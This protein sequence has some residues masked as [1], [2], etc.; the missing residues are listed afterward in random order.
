MTESAI[1][2]TRIRQQRLSQ[3]LR[4]SAL[5]QKAGISPSYLNL[6]EHNRRRIGGKIL[7]RL[8]EALNVEPQI[9]SQ[10]G[11]AAL[12]AGLREAAAEPGDTLPEAERLE[13][14]VGRF[15]GWAQLLVQAHRRGE[16]RER[17]VQALIN[18]LAH[19][20]HLAESIHEVLSVVAAI[21]STASILVETPALEPEWQARFHRNINEDAHRLTE[22]AE[23]LVQYLEAAP[24]SDTDIRSPQDELDQF[25]AAHAYHFAALEQGGDIDALVQRSDVLTLPSAVHLA[26][27]ALA[28]YVEDAAR[29]PIAGMARAL[30]HLGCDPVQLAQHLGVGL[31]VMLRRLAALP[32]EM[33]GPLG[34]VVVDGSGTMVMRKP[35]EGFA[36]T[37]LAG[38][39]PLWPVFRVLAQPGAALRQVIVQPG[40]DARAVTALACAEPVGPPIVNM[41]PLLR[42]V[43]LLSPDLGGD[44]APGPVGSSCRICARQGCVARRE[45][46]VLQDNG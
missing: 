42:G 4:Q 11:E 23:A 19:D 37:R 7:L 35:L 31:P 1:T 34:L 30:R 33:V 14:F 29:L 15:P 38:S 20:P 43:M 9:L 28:Q 22:G 44:A 26:R 41:P 45:P 21:R 32:E 27:A 39:C 24:G 3:G 10:G 8:A 2:G 17:M 40:R 25:L 36:V 18:R 6:I 46:S 16:D 13:E 5:A 12:V